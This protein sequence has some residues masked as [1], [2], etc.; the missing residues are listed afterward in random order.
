MAIEIELYQ[1]GK[2]QVNGIVKFFCSLNSLKR[3]QFIT[4]DKMWLCGDAKITF[5]NTTFPVIWLEVDVSARVLTRES[6]L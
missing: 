3:L 1:H 5:S 4:P 2:P 6:S